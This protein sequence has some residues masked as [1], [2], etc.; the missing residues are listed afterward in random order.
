M[1]SVKKSIH[2][3]HTHTHTHTHTDTHMQR[4]TCTIYQTTHRICRSSQRSLKPGSIWWNRNFLQ[5][6]TYTFRELNHNS[7][8]ILLTSV[9]SI[10]SVEA[11]GGACKIC[12]NPFTATFSLISVEVC[13][14]Q[15]CLSSWHIY[16]YKERCYS[17]SCLAHGLIILMLP[18]YNSN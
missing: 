2:T 10:K 6:A 3:D 7:S 9:K 18:F 8:R 12:E 15:L 16:L 13:S 17:K 1:T 5:K 11:S 4:G 14:L